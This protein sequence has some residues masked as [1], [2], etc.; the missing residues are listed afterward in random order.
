MIAFYIR[1]LYGWSNILPY[2]Y[3][4]LI[5]YGIL[6]LEMCEDGTKHSTKTKHNNTSTTIITIVTIIVRFLP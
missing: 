3:D 6:V 4:L 1:L 5:R 2:Y